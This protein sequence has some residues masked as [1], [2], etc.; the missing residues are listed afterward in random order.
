[1]RWRESI[2]GMRRIFLALLAGIAL[3]GWAQE[4]E[5]FNIENPAVRAYMLD[6]AYHKTDD[7]DLSIIF[8]FVKKD[9]AR[10]D[11]PNG[12]EITWEATISADKIRHFEIT[13]S[14]NEDFSDSLTYFTK[15]GAATSY[16]L[17]NMY[18]NRTY[19]YRVV[20]VP[21][22][23]SLSYDEL[24]WGTF[25]TTGQVR[26][27]FIEGA[28]NVRDMGGWMTSFGKPIQYGKMYRS[29]HL[30]RLTPAAVHEF[31][32]NQHL[33]AEHDLRGSMRKEPKLTASRVRSDIFYH[34]IVSDAYNLT[35]K[36]AINAENISWIIKCLR[37][38]R[39]IDWHCSV[40]CDRCGTVSF[41]IGG[42]LGMNEVDLTRDYELSCFAGF[43]KPR[44]HAGFRRML[45][46]IKK[47][48]PAD[49]LAQCFYNYLV[50]SGVKSED[51]D[52]LRE[53]MVLKP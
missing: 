44:N 2:D 30:D 20:Q 42:V 15:D 16:T 14:T 27:M 53:V 40:G 33:S 52:Y 28:R 34:R 8:D 12:K 43:D 51:L 50:Q 19:F 18:P 5:V 7:S 10:Q 47:F 35:S 46:Y 48:G 11:I 39:V 6:E 49:D 23:G 4:V 24:A 25:K 9:G 38:N 17:R 31:C 45:P 37:E 21:K 26:M 22:D 32:D 13:L 36:S 3:C 41:L 29:G 1:M